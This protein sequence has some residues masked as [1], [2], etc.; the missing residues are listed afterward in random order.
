MA[1]AGVSAFRNIAPAQIGIGT[2]DM[3][4]L[5]ACRRSLCKPG[6]V[7]ANPYGESGERVKSVAGKSGDVI[8]P[9]GAVDPEFS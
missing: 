8:K 4:N 7:G 2:F 5:A 1:D 6:T 3:P 9:A